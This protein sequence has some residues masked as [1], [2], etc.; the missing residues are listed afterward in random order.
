ML[1]LVW[2]LIAAFVVYVVH[3]RLLYFVGS[4]GQIEK[5][6]GVV[7]RVGEAAVAE[8]RCEMPRATVIAMH[9]F[10]ENPRYF[11][12]YYDDPDIQLITLTSGDYHVPFSGAEY[13]NAGWEATPGYALGTI[14]YD[15]AV[16]VQALAHLPKTK[17]I[18]V[19]GHSRGGAVVLEAA[20]M[21]PELFRGVEVVLEA[22]V[23]PQ[24]RSV[25][26]VIPGTMWLVPYVFLLWRRHP[27]SPLS[28]HA[29][30]RLDNE[31]KRSVIKSLPFSPRR[32]V[33]VIRNIRSIDSWMKSRDVG[34]YR[35]LERGAILIADEDHVLN[36]GA[37]RI[38]ARQA[39]GDLRIIEVDNSSHFV[40]FDRPDAVPPLARA[41]A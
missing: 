40:L 39:E 34:M 17:T 9:G 19:H 3:L 30:G 21:R 11:T 20:T 8:R 27:I 13:R 7:Y 36:S 4:P 29:F 6:D 15:A 12:Q 24:G 31:R 5:F 37:M 26:P 2:F 10:L 41:A 28:Q 32:L 1:L 38:S 23:L 18:R 14:E 33:T 16:L 22:P 35:N 25:T